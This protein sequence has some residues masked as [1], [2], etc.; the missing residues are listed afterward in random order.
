MIQA[1][2]LTL[3]EEGWGADGKQKHDCAQHEVAQTRAKAE[4]C[5]HKGLQFAI[6]LICTILYPIFKMCLRIP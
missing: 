4:D 5:K 2:N 1:K 3:S 6:K